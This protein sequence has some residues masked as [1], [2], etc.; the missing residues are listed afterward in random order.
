MWRSLS[1]AIQ[2]A[3]ERR[4]RR[5]YRRGLASWLLAVSHGNGVN[6]GDAAK[7]Y[8]VSLGIPE[9]DV[10]V[11]REEWNTRIEARI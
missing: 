8:L 4:P 7:R 10:L 3:G 2:D 6:S 11:L 5:P 9:S 1:V